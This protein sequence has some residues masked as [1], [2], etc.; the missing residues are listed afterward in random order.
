V[1]LTRHVRSFIDQ[2]RLIHQQ[3]NII[4]LA[5]RK[6]LEQEENIQARINAIELEHYREMQGIIC[7]WLI[8][9]ETPELD[10]R[11]DLAALESNLGLQ[12]AQLEEH[13]L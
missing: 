10:V 13:V 6:L 3:W 4:A 1:T 11:G 8:N 9:L 12:I 7:A 5:A 2:K